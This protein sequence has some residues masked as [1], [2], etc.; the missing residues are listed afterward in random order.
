VL[1]GGILEDRFHGEV[2]PVDARPE[3]VPTHLPAFG[4]RQVQWIVAGDG[5]IVVGYEGIKT[6]RVAVESELR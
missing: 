5:K 2:T 6:G 4:E 1:S 3:R